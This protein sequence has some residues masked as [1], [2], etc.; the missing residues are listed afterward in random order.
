[1][2]EARATILVVE[3]EPDQDFLRTSLGTAGMKVVE[4]ETGERGA[5]GAGSTGLTSQSSISACPTWTGSKSSGKSAGGRRYRS[6]FS[7]PA[8]RSK[9]RSKHLMPALTTM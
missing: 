3:D 7:P 8:P 9:R 1:M 6:S 4:A 5:T 2:S